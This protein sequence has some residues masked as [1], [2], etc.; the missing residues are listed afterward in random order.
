[1][2][3]TVNTSVHL[4]MKVSER[5]GILNAVME[6]LFANRERVLSSLVEELLRVAQEQWLALQE[7]LVCTAC[8]VVHGEEGWVRRGVRPRRLCTS[9]GTFDFSLVQLTCRACGK[10]RAIAEQALGLKPRQ[11]FSTEV[12]RK[13]VERPYDASYGRS[14][15]SAEECMRVRISRS[16][17]HGW[18]Q[19]HARRLQLRPDPQ[20]EVILADGT[21]VRAGTRVELE[22]LRAAFQFVRR[23]T[24][25]PRPRAILRLIGLEVGPRTWPKVLRGD[26]Q[27]R[28]VVTDAEPALRP[29]IR[30]VY[31]QA[32][33][34]QC[35]WHVTHTLDWSLRE[36]GVALDERKKL[37]AELSSILW[38]QR[39]P[40][41]KRR[42]YTQ[43]VERLR[44]YPKSH[45]QLR[46]ARAYI[47]FATPSKMRTTSLIERQIREVDRRALVGVRWSTSGLRNLLLLSFAKRHNPDDYQQL[48]YAN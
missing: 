23:D 35:E 39:S 31:P 33:H 14:V 11:R 5:T 41:T 43:Y 44:Q 45:R 28:L 21:K 9:S 7:E 22:D 32:R 27:T 19:A 46:E 40:A 10:T 4:E 17:L 48:W 29:H 8:G 20:A 2:L 6:W 38:G 30:K 25:G 37:R 42:L 16:T 36:D 24:Q 34:Q 18:V 26:G 47:L 3:L 13:L 12:Q 1:M 15:R